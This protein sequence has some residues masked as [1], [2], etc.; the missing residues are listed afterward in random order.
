MSS[1]SIAA[2]AAAQGISTVAGTAL[3]TKRRHGHRESQQSE[4]ARQHLQIP[5]VGFPLQEGNGNLVRTTRPI[6]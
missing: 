1:T 6:P 4:L 5:P 3:V 2:A